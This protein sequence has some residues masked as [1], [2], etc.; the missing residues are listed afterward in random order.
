MLPGEPYAYL[1][2]DDLKTGFTDKAGYCFTGTA[3]RNG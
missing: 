2:K 3:M 1:G